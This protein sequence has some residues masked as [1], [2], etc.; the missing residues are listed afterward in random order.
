MLRR[1][2]REKEPHFCNGSLLVIP[3]S[4]KSPEM[5]EEPRVSGVDHD[6]TQKKRRAFYYAIIQHFLRRKA[7]P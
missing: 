7:L 2:L 1:L 5:A 6:T 3:Q 4:R